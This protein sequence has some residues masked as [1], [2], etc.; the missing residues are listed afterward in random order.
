VKL[1]LRV[2][3]GR[4]VKDLRRLD[5][6]NAG[7]ILKAI[8]RFAETGHGDVKALVGKPGEYRIR[9]GDMR[10][11]FVVIEDVLRVRRIGHRRE[12]YD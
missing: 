6:R 12:I 5:K 11:I 4:A 2:E 8:E 9:A 3:I 10:A 7:R 1:P